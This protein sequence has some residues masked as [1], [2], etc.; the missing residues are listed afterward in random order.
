MTIFR[1]S[2]VVAAKGQV[3]CDLA[4]EVA[5]LDM[6]SGIYYGLNAVGARLW[7]LI[8]EPKLVSELCEVILREFDVEA[9][10]CERD[11]LALLQGLA[12]EGL[13]EVRNGTAA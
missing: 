1:N 13:V 3:S 11:V 8:Q 7:N 5:I 10:R 2:T 12:A 9:D 4:G 6:K